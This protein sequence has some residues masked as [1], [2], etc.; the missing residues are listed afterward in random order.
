MMDWHQEVDAVMILMM[1]AAVVVIALMVPSARSADIA[2]PKLIGWVA[3]VVAVLVALRLLPGPI[4]VLVGLPIVGI[5]LLG[6]AVWLALSMS[7]RAGRL[8]RRNDR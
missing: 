5:V 4:R 3:S 6:G 8:G 7:R 1:V 2:R